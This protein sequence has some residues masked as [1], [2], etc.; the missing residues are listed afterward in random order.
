MF[1]TESCVFDSML[2]TM[3]PA[4][5]VLKLGIS[6]VEL[7]KWWSQFEKIRLG[8]DSVVAE[9]LLLYYLCYSYTVCL[10]VCSKCSQCWSHNH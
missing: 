6:G 7:F 3:M 5:T 2:H 10:N 4:H 8:A 1:V 9:V